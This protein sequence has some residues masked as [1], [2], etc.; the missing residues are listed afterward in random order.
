VKHGQKTAAAALTTAA[1]QINDE[2]RQSVEADPSL[3]QRYAAAL[4]RAARRDGGGV[5]T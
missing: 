1:R 2:I 3:R 4:R 5:P